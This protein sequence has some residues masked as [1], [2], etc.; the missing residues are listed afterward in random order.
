VHRAVTD[1]NLAGMTTLRPSAPPHRI[2][3]GPGPSE[4]APEVLAAL[5]RPTLGHLDPLFLA[6]MDDVRAGLR[7][8]FR[9]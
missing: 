5:A 2:L 1:R 7:A 3:L 4:C 6:L 8:A 9:T